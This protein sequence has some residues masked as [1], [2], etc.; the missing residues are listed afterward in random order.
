MA[1]RRIECIFDTLREGEKSKEEAEITR[2]A[3][4]QESKYTDRLMRCG[5]KKRKE[6]KAMIRDEENTKL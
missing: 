5:K 1:A 3:L 6:K 4:G 2:R